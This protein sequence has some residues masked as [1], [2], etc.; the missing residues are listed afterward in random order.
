MNNM[1]DNSQNG[2]PGE[3][4]GANAGGMPNAGEISSASAGADTSTGLGAGA[5]L[6]ADAGMSA[7]MI[8]E[9]MPGANESMRAGIGAANT[10][11]TPARNT[12]AG[13]TGEYAAGAD[14]A[15]T[16]A[17]NTAAAGASAAADLNANGNT[18]GNT[19]YDSASFEGTANGNTTSRNNAGGSKFAKSAAGIFTALNTAENAPGA[20]N[21]GINDI[22]NDNADRIADNTAGKAQTNTISSA[23]SKNS[24]NATANSYSQSDSSPSDCSPSDSSKPESQHSNSLPADEGMQDFGTALSKSEADRRRDKLRRKNRIYSRI[25]LFLSIILALAGAGVIAY[26]YIMQQI[27]KRKQTETVKAAR[28]RAMEKTAQEREEI[29]KAA[30]E[31][32]QK[33][34]ENG[35]PALGEK[36]DPFK[37][38]D[39]SSQTSDDKDRYDEEYLNTLDISDGQM[40]NVVVPSVS[41]NLPVK[42]GTS[43][44]VL[45]HEIGHL[46]GTSLPVGGENTHTVLTG[47]RGMVGKLMFTRIDEL[48]NGD[49]FYI[50]FFDQTIG[51]KIDSI[52]VVLPEEAEQYLKIRPG[53]DRATLLTCTP[54]GVNTHRLLVSGIRASIPNEAP[55]P[56]Y[57]K[58]KLWPYFWINAGIG[59]MTLTGWCLTG[60]RNRWK[61]M[62]HASERRGL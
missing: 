57:P 33:L 7:S 45:D 20:A 3:T 44:A 6:S 51:Y 46:Y 49:C 5:G 35:Q 34:F 36:A 1:R 52:R 9:T 10:E 59:T 2:L 19:T 29:L 43:K 31:Y 25:S 16:A 58:D 39:E 37:S 26:P 21:V 54:Y 17:R 56:D 40:G 47:H 22:A 8:A 27:D 50:Q 30:Y 4:Q 55:G 12:T 53:E 15:G 38:E 41:I 61:I 60:N 11:S 62:R 13:N 23:N 28:A 32:N 42:H 24:A 48:K 18:T 14:A